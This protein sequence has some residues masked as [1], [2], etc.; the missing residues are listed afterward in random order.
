MNSNFQSGSCLRCIVITALFA[1]S[2]VAKAFSQSQSANALY[3]KDG[4]RV[5]GYVM[6]LDSAGSVRIQNTEGK[7]QEFRMSDV[8]AII[9]SYDVTPPGPGAIYRY[10]DKYRWKRNDVELSDRDFEKYFDDELYHTYVGGSNQFNLGGACWVYS[11]TCAVISVLMID[12]KAKKQDSSVYIY[13]AGA[14]ILA[15]LGGVFTGIGKGRMD[16]VERTFNERNAATNEVSYSAKGINSVK[17][18]P[19]L[20]MS[21]GNDLALGATLSIS[22]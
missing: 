15:C 4:S 16:W 11:I 13:A 14:N 8:D 19:S 20:M 12:P 17:L 9:W 1:F 2:F 22:F 6:E 7:M 18:N 21:T 3:L 10:G 5:V